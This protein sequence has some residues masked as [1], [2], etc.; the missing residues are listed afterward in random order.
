MINQDPH[1]HYMDIMR[2]VIFW[3]D[4]WILEDTL[5]HLSDELQASPQRSQNQHGG[6]EPAVQCKARKQFRNFICA[7]LMSSRFF[8]LNLYIH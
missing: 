3:T 1:D 2:S 5:F 4:M 6:G 7:M 8:L